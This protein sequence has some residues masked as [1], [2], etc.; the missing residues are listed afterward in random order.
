[1][2][3]PK[4]E[5]LTRHSVWARRRAAPARRKL[6]KVPFVELF[7]GRLQGVVSSGSDPRRVYV[8]F[9]EAGTT[10]FYC[11]TNNNRPCGGLRGSPCKHLAA[12]ME[13]AVAQYGV[14]RVVRYLRLD[15]GGTVPAPHALPRYVTGSQKK[16]PANEV[17]SRFLDYL[18]YVELD[19]QVAP[20][21]EMSWFVTG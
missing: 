2:A 3:D 16:T 18:R 21:P 20:M 12:L 4:S 9:F 1:M 8:S 6:A 11:S 15:T 17:F 5:D 14:D 19:G 7:G 10:D 13:N